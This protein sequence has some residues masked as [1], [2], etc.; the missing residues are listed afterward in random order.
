MNPKSEVQSP[1]S[2]PSE[3]TLGEFWAGRETVETVLAAEQPCHTSLR[4]DVNERFTS[5]DIGHWTL[6]FGLIY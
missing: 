2:Y 1:K 5:P 4:R 6:D 3:R